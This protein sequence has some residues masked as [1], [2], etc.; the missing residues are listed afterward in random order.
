MPD[1]SKQE[2]DAYDK[3]IDAAADLAEL[4][5]SSGIEMD[6]YALE[7][8]TIFLARHA[9]EVRRIL[10]GVKQTCPRG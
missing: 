6:E 8:L 4:I 9:A 10:K 1:R 3:M 2:A 5:E 7:E